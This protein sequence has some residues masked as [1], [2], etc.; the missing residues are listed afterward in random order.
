MTTSNAQIYRREFYR[1]GKAP[2]H[3]FPASAEFASKNFVDFFGK[4]WLPANPSALSFDAVVRPFYNEAEP[5]D[6]KLFFKIFAVADGSIIQSTAE[7]EPWL[8]QSIRFI[9]LVAGN[10]QPTV[11]AQP[12]DN[13]GSWTL[14]VV[15][16]SNVDSTEEFMQTASWDGHMFRYYERAVPNDSTTAD[17]VWIFNGDSMGA[18]G[19]QS[20][21]GPFNGHVNGSLVM[22]ELKR[23]WIHWLVEGNNFTNNISDSILAKFDQVPYLTDVPDPHKNSTRTLP[24]VTGADIMELHVESAINKW[25]NTRQKMDFV[26]EKSQPLVEVSNVQRWLAHVLLSTT[27]NMTTALAAKTGTYDNIFPDEHFYNSDLFGTSSAAPIQPLASLTG[28]GFHQNAYDIAV[29]AIGLA[30]VQAYPPKGSPQPDPKKH[31]DAGSIIIG[32]DTIGAFIVEPG[33]GENLRCNILQPSYE[34]VQGALTLLSKKKAP[35]LSKDCLYAMLMVDP[36]NPVYSWRRGV[37]LQYVPEST[38]LPGPYDPKAD[39]PQQYDLESV[40]EAAVRA[41]PRFANE[42]D[43]PEQEFIE[44]LEGARNKTLN[45]NQ[46]MTDYLTKVSQRLTDPNQVNEAMTDYLKL[47]ESRRRIYRPVPLD[48]FDLTLPWATRWPAPDTRYEMTRQGTIVEMAPRGQKFFA[49][50]ISSLASADPQMIPRPD[51]DDTD[52]ARINV[53]ASPGHDVI[54]NRTANESCQSSSIQAR[55]IGRCPALSSRKKRSVRVDHSTSASSTT[56]PTWE[57]DI[58]NLFSSPYWIEPEEKR[59]QI[60][61]AWIGMMHKYGPPIPPWDSAAST[62]GLD[63]YDQVKLQAVTIYQHVASRSMPITSDPS[64]YWPDSAVQLL[65]T[66]INQGCRKTFNEPIVVPQIPVAPVTSPVFRTRKD[67]RCLTH[68]ELSTYRDRLHSVLQVETLNSKW[69]ELGELHAWWCLHYQEATFFWHRCYLHHIEELI[70]FPIPY[71][72]GFATDTADPKSPHAGLPSVFLEDTYTALDGSKRR[73]PLKWALSFGGKSKSDPSKTNCQRNPILEKGR[74]TEPG[75]ARDAW[76]QHIGLFTK[77]HQQIVTAMQQPTFSLPQFNPATGI[78]AEAA[79]AAL[80]AFTEDM[81]D[82]DYA[83]AWSTFDGHFEQAHDNFHGWVGGTQGEMADNTYTAFDPI[84]LSY[85]CNMDRLFEHYLRANPATKVTADFP[86][87]PFVNRAKTL[88]FTN[89]N[90][91]AYTSTSEV[92]R[93]TAA[94]GYTYAPPAC[95]DILQLAKPTARTSTA[96]G[97]ASVQ[98]LTT[99]RAAVVGGVRKDSVIKTADRKPVILFEDIVCTPTSFIVD[100]FLHGAQSLVAD[101][102]KNSNFNRSKEEEKEEK[103]KEEEEEE[104]KEE[105]KEEEEEE[106]EKEEKEE[107]EEE[108]EKEKDKEDKRDA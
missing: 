104:E 85:H 72:N 10:E 39:P 96:S 100:I 62:L 7:N 13:Q 23:P 15:G 94:L 87:R 12:F 105:E 32:D 26:D 95:P 102:S 29:D 71:W 101:P 45:F 82:A 63:N 33:E 77:Y 51:K 38:R 21:L 57:N 97:G 103:E 34:D 2:F 86:L 25:L 22:K 75:P 49:D 66:W 61:Q 65:H 60:G 4:T 73:N 70:D 99:P 91:W 5:P 16:S 79:W 28:F 90:S 68:T 81:D 108:E 50:W 37:L 107:K 52:G 74:P 35:M 59:K 106:E 92:A 36:W 93:P 14:C 47:A 80:P 46:T 64:H 78:H 40:I 43:S 30:L 1:N 69:Q 53:F 8:D 3:D 31:P 56:E 20:Y 54:S 76:N 58:K 48:E 84:F 89:P 17:P 11:K 98:M 18:F 41:S 19:D 55:R 9:A 24:K 44:N 67:I 42:V 88:D 6:S 83:V 27:V